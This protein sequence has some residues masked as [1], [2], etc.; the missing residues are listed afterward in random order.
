M[1]FA[2]DN[3]M[4][5]SAPVL[6]AIM[7]TNSGPMPAYG[8]D[9]LTQAIEERF[10]DIF[11][12]DVAVFLT[13]TG[14]G[15]NALALS[16]LVPPYGMVLCHQEAHVIDDECGA[17]EF[18]MHGAKL[19]GLPGDDSKLA[20]TDVAAFLDGLTRREK[21][22]P[23]R[24]LSVAQLTESGTLYG[25]DEIAAICAA[26]HE[27]GLKVHMDGARFANALVTLG[28]TPAEMTW[29]AGVDV[30]TFGATKNGCLAAEAI[31]FFDPALA[32][33]MRWLRKRGGHTLSKGR[34]LGAQFEGYL[35]DD[36]WLDNARH[37]NAMADRLAQGLTALPGFRLAFPRGGNEVFV[38]TKAARAAA[39]R[40]KGCVFNDWSAASIPEARAPASDEIV[41]R[42]VA[43][44]AATPEGVDAFLAVAAQT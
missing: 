39:M 3:V 38:V 7:A 18:F 12:R 11:E 4:G 2:S 10:R 14:T 42:L 31:V 36:H 29:K 1:N 25:L 32:E 43:S 24:A 20:V 13:A 26:A 44:F 40:A 16:A 37:A 15:A 17:P 19:V 27:R 28:A 35:A 41:A 23:P 6:E 22:M 5:A 34:L 30:L 21:Q 33:P 8:A 9:P